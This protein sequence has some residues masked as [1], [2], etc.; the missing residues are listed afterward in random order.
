MNPFSLDHR[1]VE[2]GSRATRLPQLPAY[3]GT[4]LPGA[5]A[6]QPPCKG[7]DPGVARPT[8]SFAPRGWPQLAA[9]AGRPGPLEMSTFSPPAILYPPLYNEDERFQENRFSKL[10]YSRCLLISKIY[11]FVI[12]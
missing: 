12:V 5:G 8:G 6:G 7:S 9:A 10:H 4:A 3:T 1:P 2:E 11:K